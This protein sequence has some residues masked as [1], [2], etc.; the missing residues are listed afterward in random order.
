MIWARDYNLDLKRK[1]VLM[2]MG[3]GGYLGNGKYVAEEREG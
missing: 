2:A 1:R 3:T